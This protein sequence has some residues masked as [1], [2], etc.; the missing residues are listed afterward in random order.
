MPHP[1]LGVINVQTMRLRGLL[2]D[3]GLTAASSKLGGGSDA[4]AEDKWGGLLDAVG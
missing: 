3:L 4:K 1:M 2:A